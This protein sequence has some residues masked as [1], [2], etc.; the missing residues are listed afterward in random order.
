M[1]AVSCEKDKTYSGPT[2]RVKEIYL[3]EKLVYE[4]N[5]DVVDRINSYIEYGQSNTN[6]FSLRYSKNEISLGYNFDNYSHG[7]CVFKLDDDGYIIESKD[8]DSY[9]NNNE[10]EYTNNY[11]TKRN[12]YYSKYFVWKNG[13]M[14]LNNEDAIEYSNIRNITNIDF[15]SL[16][17]LEGSSPLGLYIHYNFFPLIWKHKGLASRD[18]I[19]S[20]THSYGLAVG[21]GG[22]PTSC[23]EK[24]SVEYRLDDDGAP[25]QIIINSNCYYD[26]GSFKSKDP[27][28]YRITY[29]K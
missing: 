19:K 8:N 17:V 16:Y 11:I 13:N 1:M 28:I 21:S 6:R 9:Q 25:I 15:N 14:Y 24:T 29:V 5:Y 20:A 23:T 4:F 7:N 26:D 18:L 3:D 10:Y 2:K 27:Q 22:G 12:G